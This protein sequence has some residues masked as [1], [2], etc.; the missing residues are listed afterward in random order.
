MSL[1]P[2]RF[3]ILNSM[4]SDQPGELFQS[5]APY[6]QKYVPK[7]R[8]DPPYPTLCQ[9]ENH[10]LFSGSAPPPADQPIVEL[11]RTNRDHEWNIKIFLSKYPSDIHFLV[12]VKNMLLYSLTQH[13]SGWSTLQ[14]SSDEDL[15]PMRLSIENCKPKRL[16]IFRFDD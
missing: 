6:L 11:T 13:Q 14:F 3:P 1:E 8:E 7:Q 16:I 9:Q 12:Q 10:S 4:L 15:L 5:K 2:L